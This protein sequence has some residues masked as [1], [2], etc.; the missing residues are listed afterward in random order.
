MTGSFV[1]CGN[2]KID[3]GPKKSSLKMSF[4]RFSTP[5]GKITTFMENVVDKRNIYFK[6][7]IFRVGIFN[8]M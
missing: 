5:C 8:L 4:S 3:G 7:S 1:K 2:E 6:N